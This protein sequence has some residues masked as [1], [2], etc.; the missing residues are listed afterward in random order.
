MLRPMP[1]AHLGTTLASRTFPEHRHSIAADLARLKDAR[2]FADRAAQAF[3]FAEEL[4]YQIKLAMSEAVAN[5][6]QHGSSSAADR[7]D[8]SAAD[9]GGTLAFYVSDSGTFIPRMAPRGDLPE[10]GRGL[11]FVGQL[12]DEVDVRPGSDGTVLRFAKRLGA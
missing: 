3:G 10:R 1:R 7:I 9:E 2:D 12:M 4:R 11:E 5:A 6:I 8:L